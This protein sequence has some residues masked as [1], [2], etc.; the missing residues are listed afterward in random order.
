MNT[1]YGL[2]FLKT[3]QETNNKKQNVKFTIYVSY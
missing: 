2:C 1:G 3:I